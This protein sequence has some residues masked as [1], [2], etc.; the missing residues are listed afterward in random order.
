MSLQKLS[1]L[2]LKDHS[3]ERGV[4]P[5]EGIAVILY[6]ALHASRLGKEQLQNCE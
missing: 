1:Y 5:E 2:L 6:D 4:I 3:M